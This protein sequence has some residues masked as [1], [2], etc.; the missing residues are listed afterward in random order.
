MA[1]IVVVDETLPP[2]LKLLD[3]VPGLTESRVPSLRRVSRENFTAAEPVAHH[4]RPTG[5]VVLGTA[6]ILRGFLSWRCY[7]EEVG[8]VNYSHSQ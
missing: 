3:G 1:H 4:P 6:K 8:L 7:M 5:V 2:M